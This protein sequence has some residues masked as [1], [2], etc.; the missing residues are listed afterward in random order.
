M[1]P[2]FL[3]QSSNSCASIYCLSLGAVRNPIGIVRI[4][5]SFFSF[6]SSS[7]SSSLLHSQW[8]QLWTPVPS[9]TH[10]LLTWLTQTLFPTPIV[11]THA[12]WFTSPHRALVL[13]IQSPETLKRLCMHLHYNCAVCY[14][15]QCQA[16]LAWLISLPVSN[17]CLYILMI[18]AL[19]LIQFL[20]INYLCI[21]HNLVPPR[22]LYDNFHK[23]WNT[24]AN[25]S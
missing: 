20:L 13:I 22:E 23:L 14:V 12:F 24:F 18:S 6:F 21:L 5:L 3:N 17:L 19:P 1:I 7:T 2:W 10:G 8:N 16:I 9:L 25:W 11:C 4:F 15:W